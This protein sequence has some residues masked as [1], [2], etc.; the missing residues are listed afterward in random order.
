MPIILFCR[1]CT[2]A[3]ESRGAVP[4][5]CPACGQDTWWGTSPPVVLRLTEMDKQFLR[6]NHI[7]PGDRE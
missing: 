3:Y 2:A 4:Q 6:V 1:R 5:Q 7:D